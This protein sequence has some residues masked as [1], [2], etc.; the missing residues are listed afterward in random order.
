[1][2]RHLLSDDGTQEVPKHEADCVIYC[3]HTYSLFSALSRKSFRLWGN[4]KNYGIHTGYRWR[5]NT[6]HACWMAKSTDTHS[7]YVI[8]TAFPLQQS[9]HERASVIGLTD[10]PITC[11]VYNRVLARGVWVGC[12]GQCR[13]LGCHRPIHT[14]GPEDDTLWDDSDPDCLP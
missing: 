10:R 7:E 13:T 3:V 14:S 5:C 11:L 2:F 9:L 4:V 8:I 6:E 12:S 1:M